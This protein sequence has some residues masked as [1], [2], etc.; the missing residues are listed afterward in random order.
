LDTK[1]VCNAIIEVKCVAGKGQ[2]TRWKWFKVVTLNICLYCSLIYIY[3]TK[4]VLFN[5]GSAKHVMRFREGS[6]IFR[7]NDF[8]LQRVDATSNFLYH[9]PAFRHQASQLVIQEVECR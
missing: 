7:G 5:R 6:S 9:C 2:T 1:Y 8:L 3:K 4:A